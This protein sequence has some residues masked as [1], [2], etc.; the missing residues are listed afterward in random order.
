[1]C[2]TFLK[3]VFPY[4]TFSEDREIQIER[5]PEPSDVLWENLNVSYVTRLYKTITIF[6]S[7]LI[8]I[9]VCFGS[10]F[11][12]D[13]EQREL[14]K[15]QEEEKKMGILNQKR[16]I[17]IRVISFICAFVIIIINNLLKIIVKYLTTKEKHETNTAFNLSLAVKLML[18]RFVNT[19]IV[20]VI[21]NTKIGEWFS[22]GGLVSDLFSIMV[23]I[24][25]IDPIL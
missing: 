17:E 20:P 24:S 6:V 9:G 14:K 23:S 13:L 21:I 22:E 8:L 15:K 4:C 18:A 25:V 3:F 16:E 11:G 19:A 12:L 5:A 2:Y 1:M 10:I 7:I